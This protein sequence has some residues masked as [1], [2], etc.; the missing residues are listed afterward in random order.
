M[1]V[2]VCW[3][4]SLYIDEEGEREKKKE[5]EGERGRE[6]EKGLRRSEHEYTNQSSDFNAKTMSSIVPRVTDI[7]MGMIELAALY[8]EVKSSPKTCA[9]DITVEIDEWHNELV[10]DLGRCKAKLETHMAYFNDQRQRV[11]RHLKSFTGRKALL[12]NVTTDPEFKIISIDP[13]EVLLEAI[14]LTEK[15]IL[16]Y[17]ASVADIDAMRVEHTT[18]MEGIKA[19]KRDL[20][21]AIQPIATAA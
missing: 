5:R 3:L 6:R 19:L 8:S 12:I 16:Q 21:Q 17:N 10:N 15:A 18:L 20:K 9:N 2:C 11:L 1:K 7:Q 4:S 13:K 14:N